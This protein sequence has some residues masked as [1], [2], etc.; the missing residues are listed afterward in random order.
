[1][2]SYN[3]VDL[4][5]LRTPVI[6]I[7]TCTN[8]M[9]TISLD[10]TFK[11]LSQLEDRLRNSAKGHC[12]DVELPIQMRLEGPPGVEI[13]CRPPFWAKIRATPIFGQ[14]RYNYYLLHDS[15]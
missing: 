10:P 13:L 5:D 9:V 12:M 8:T 15:P 3:L 1:M 11:G 7:F 6:S 2:S 14:A 4:G